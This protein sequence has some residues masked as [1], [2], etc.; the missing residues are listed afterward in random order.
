M[1]DLPE[2]Q[3]LVRRIGTLGRE[4]I[5]QIVRLSPRTVNSYLRLLEGNPSHELVSA[6]SDYLKAASRAELHPDPV[7]LDLFREADDRLGKEIAAL[8]GPEKALLAREHAQRRAALLTDAGE[9]AS[10]AEAELERARTRIP[11]PGG[12]VLDVMAARLQHGFLTHLREVA[13]LGSSSW[14]QG[15]RLLM[16]GYRKLS[17]VIGVGWRE[18]WE[19]AFTYLSQNLGELAQR[20]KRLKAA[21][22]ALQ[23]ALAVGNP[24]AVAA[25]TEAELAARQSA[26]GYLSKLKG[27]IGEAYVPRWK[28]WLV[29]IES[30]EEVARREA[31]ELPGQW[32][33][34]SIA[35]NLRL[36]GAETWDQA[37]LLT[38]AG[39]PGSPPRAKLF[40]AGQFKIEKQVTALEQVERD[41]IRETAT[42]AE[43]ALPFLTFEGP[44]GRIEGWFLE[45]MPA[46]RQSHRY[47]FNASGG[48]F[49][50][51]DILRL[52]QAGI[53]VEQLN[54]DVSTAEMDAIA[55]VLLDI[56]V[57][58]V[59]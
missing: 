23:Q 59:P 2:A 17:S 24:A 39:S 33:V 48:K 21:R 30:F 40:L 57:G 22:E 42:S 19:P 9:L 16:S 41:A 29:Q 44:D 27:L 11:R 32:T 10:Q 37:I 15:Q 50:K 46:G 43:R 26:G 38:R 5:T 56:V 45:P 35:G 36:D 25:A 52:R 3:E 49:S 7:I 12:Q 34:R 18:G 13:A 53:K 1:A 47:V 28:D 14:V 54:L 51:A 55:N 20:G 4:E 6:V 8:S 31:A 58:L